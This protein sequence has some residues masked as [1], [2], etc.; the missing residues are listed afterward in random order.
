MNTQSIA[1]K[2]NGNSHPKKLLKDHLFNC[3]QLADQIERFHNIKIEM[4]DEILTH[5]A[6]KAHPLFQKH[7]KNSTF[8]FPHSEPSSHLTFLITQNILSAEVV[9]RHHGSFENFENVKSYWLSQSAEQLSESINEYAPFVCFSQPTLNKTETAIDHLLSQ[10]NTTLE[11][12]FELRLKAS[13]LSTA[14]R[15]EAIGVNQIPYTHPQ[16]LQSTEALIQKLPKNHLSAWRNELRQQV[17]Q[18]TTHLKTPGI[19]TLTLPTGSGKTLIG[20][21]IANQ[22][23]AK[24]LIYA[25][26]YISIIDQNAKI[27][28]NIYK[29]IQQDHYLAPTENSEIPLDQFVQAFR[30]WLS[31]VIITTFVSLWNTLYSP[32]YN[33]T[34][35]F[36]R[37]VNSVIILDEVQTLP[38][39]YWEGFLH[40][41]RFLSRKM[42]LTVLM[43]TA[44]QPAST[45]NRELSKKLFF[46]MN[47]HIYRY[48]HE[49][50]MDDIINQIDPKKSNMIILNTRKSALEAFLKSKR[51]FE[52]S[53]FLSKWIIPK[54][55][56]KRI[57]E[58]K[59]RENFGKKR[60]V[61]TTQLVEAGV[62]LDFDQVIRDMAPLDSIIQSGGRC[63]RNMKNK[64]G[65]IIICKLLDHLNRPYASYIYDKILLNITNDLLERHLDQR[66]DEYQMNSFLK[67]YF[68]QIHLLA[69]KEGP[70]EV[71]KKGKWGEWY[72]LILKRVPEASLIVDIDGK[73]KILLDELEN[74]PKGIEQLNIKRRIWKKI[75]ENIITVP[76]IEIELW[77]D[78][79]THGI[80][81][82]R[83][84]EIVQRSEWLYYIAPSCIGTIYTEETG[85]IPFDMRQSFVYSQ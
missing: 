83:Q 56:R 34:M 59:K 24:T 36:H 69:K 20:L 55:R 28:Q 1:S 33:D 29:E 52:D 54:E 22:L 15:M 47:R 51:T 42:N 26:P 72:P 9:R 74:L 44:T 46:P 79:L 48:T 40:T 49:S 41:I 17:L 45:S 78:H 64:I 37:L 73:A 5:D 53:F 3:L 13:I 25:L 68:H 30:Y 12:W 10:D 67:D 27:A 6:A 35:N 76:K 58:I 81:D 77:S 21:E 61:I 50:K 66:I 8:R 75:G 57:E 85:F 32:R 14:D 60:Q 80:I 11:D 31:P 62:D 43:M 38:P 7:L 4:T 65:T 19:Y 63:N 2:L 16:I 70:W 18:K 84:S 82:E 71:I 23:N 39:Q